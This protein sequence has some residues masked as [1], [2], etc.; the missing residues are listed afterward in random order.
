[1]ENQTQH[2]SKHNKTYRKKLNTSP[3]DFNPYFNYRQN[4][5]QSYQRSLLDDKLLCD[6][7]LLGSN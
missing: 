2:I 1:M 3:L 6:W 5:D 4:F 7:L